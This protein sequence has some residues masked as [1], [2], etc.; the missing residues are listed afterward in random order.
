MNEIE[1][2]TDLKFKINRCTS[3]ELYGLVHSSLVGRLR[4]LMGGEE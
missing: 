3:E 2:L 1:F 4:K